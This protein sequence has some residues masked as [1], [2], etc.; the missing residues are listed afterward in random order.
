[1]VW[2]LSAGGTG[3]ALAVDGGAAVGAGGMAHYSWLYGVYFNFVEAVET[4]FD[5]YET[6]LLRS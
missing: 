3:L 1:M 5:Q 6:R 4:L 2:Y